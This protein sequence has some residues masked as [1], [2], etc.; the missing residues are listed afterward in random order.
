MRHTDEDLVFRCLDGDTE[1]F[2]ELVRRYQHAVYATAYHYAGRYGGA[3]DISQ[4]VFWTAYR[5]L[6]QIREAE[7]FGA[8][9]KGIATRISANWLRRNA[10]RLRHETP[11]PR[12]RAMFMQDM[13]QS[14]HDAHAMEE[15]YEA[16]HRAVDALPERYQLPVVL[17]YVQELSYEEISRFTGE[18]FNE[19]RGILSRASQMLRE[20]LMQQDNEESNHQEMA[21]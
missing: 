5:C 14:P 20:N 4:E 21:E 6:P 11:L 2:S 13:T 8:W 12:R 15:E 10:P 19:I 9:I 1:A 18:S 16:I 7:R 3:E 17:R